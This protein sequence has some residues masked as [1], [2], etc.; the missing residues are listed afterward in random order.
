MYDTRWPRPG[1]AMLVVALLLGLVIGGVFGFTSRSGANQDGR[2]QT[3]TTTTRGATATSRP[4]SFWTVIMSSPDSEDQ[5]D[6]D[7]A[8]AKENGVPDAFPVSSDQ[9]EPVATDYAICSGTFTTEAQATAHAERM[10][11]LRYS[12]NPFPR[13]LTRKSPG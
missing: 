13:R 11:E 12:G 5:R 1:P 6:R 2:D 3:T 4:T 7:L 9:W 8:K 10:Q